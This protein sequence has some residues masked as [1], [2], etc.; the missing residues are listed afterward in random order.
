MR[1]K[2]PVGN[3]DIREQKL[4]ENHLNNFHLKIPNVIN[5]KKRERKR[6]MTGSVTGFSS[7]CKKV[8]FCSPQ[9]RMKRGVRDPPTDGNWGVYNGGGLPLG[10]SRGTRT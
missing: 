7:Q 10:C 1:T 3:K 2:R 4:N 9:K 8:C 6:P 5:G